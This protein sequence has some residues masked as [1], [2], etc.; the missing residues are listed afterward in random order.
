MNS[1]YQVP[2][3]SFPTD[4]TFPQPG[5]QTG[6]DPDK[7]RSDIPP[8]KPDPEPNYQ[9]KDDPPQEPD[10]PQPRSLFLSGALRCLASLFQRIGNVPR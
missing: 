6:P 10:S 7:P 1:W 3:Q 5:Q 2:Q 4:V 8:Q 9:R